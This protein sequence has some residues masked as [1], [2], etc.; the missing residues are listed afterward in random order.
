[1]EQIMSAILLE[2]EDLSW[3][4]VQDIG[5]LREQTDVDDHPTLD[6]ENLG[7][8]RGFVASLDM[9]TDRITKLRL[10]LNAKDFLDLWRS[11]AEGLDYFIFSSIRW[12]EVSFA[13]SGV[14]QLRVDIKALLHV[15]RPFCSR[16]EAFLPFLIES[17]RLLSMR[18]ADVQCLL[19]M[20]AHDAKSDNSL[21]QQ[22]LHHVNDSQAAN[23]LRSRTFGG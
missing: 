16:P 12:G 5:L 6:E 14:T 3:E 13:D 23:I 8:S 22:G 11:V 9:L 15:F 17:R 2:F 19:E 18:E 21:R 10:H 7:V 20:L 4:Y 1:L